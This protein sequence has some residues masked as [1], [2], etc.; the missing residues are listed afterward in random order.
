MNLTNNSSSR[1]SDGGRQKWISVSEIDLARVVR[2]QDEVARRGGKLR[3]QGSYLVGA[4]LV[5]G[6]DDRFAI[7]IKKQLWNCR[8]CGVGG[9][10]IDFVRHVDGC[11]FES[12]ITTLIGARPREPTPAVRPVYRDENKKERENLDRAETIWRE[13][14]PL[15]RDAITYFANRCIDINQV[16]EHAGLRF[17]LRCPWGKGTTP[18]IIGRFT[19]V[20]G[21][22]PRGI[23][24]R[25]ITGETPKS[26]GP[27]AGCVIRLWPEEAV[28]RGLVLGEG[29]ET[30]LA[31]ATR[32]SHR[33]TLLQPAWVAGGSCNIRKFPI[34]SGIETLTLLVDH[35]RP[36]RHDRRAG[37]E[38]AAECAARWCAAGREV[39]RLTPKVLG[40]DFNDVV[41]HE[42]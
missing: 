14:T 38:A 28:E 27:T 5:C 34:L 4:C 32:I 17:H 11:D 15:G 10:V 22:E 23:R 39:I 13:A 30:V 21:N 37:Q 2:I 16:P 24:R 40:A 26:L 18:A 33:G 31:A 35:D 12:A 25:P 1:F 7:N 6:G 20:L 9:D 29:V 42:R 41:M 3:R 19:T 8:G 36:D